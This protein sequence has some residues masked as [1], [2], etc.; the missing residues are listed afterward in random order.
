M[1]CGFIFDMD[2]T[3]FDTEQISL[4]AM[5]VVAEEFGIRLSMEFKLGLLGLPSEAIAER[6]YDA[7]GREF[8]FDGFR[9]RKIQVQDAVIEETGV[10]I[11]AGLTEILEYGKNHG[12]RMAVATSTSRKRAMS[13]LE[14]AG[15][16]DYFQCVI[17]GD[18]IQN[19]KPHP[20]IFLTAASSLGIA[21]E[22]CIAFEDSRNG[23]LAAH[24]ANMFA[25]LIPDKI[26]PD[27]EMKAA[28]DLLCNS[29]VDAK[30][31]LETHC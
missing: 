18:S 7:F 11:K 1:N 26:A 8:D 13:L 12:I 29:L 3:M 4:D 20:E 22:R 10:P 27:Q 14:E 25:V 24:R 15:V 9:Q 5:D 16:I 2:G 28:A 6:F 30:K 23:I 19:G 31:Y 21:P 17:C